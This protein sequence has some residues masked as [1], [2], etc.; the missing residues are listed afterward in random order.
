MNG[1]P[2]D[3]GDEMTLTLRT[4]LFLAA[5]GLFFVFALMG[6]DVLGPSEHNQLVL[7]L[8]LTSFAAAFLAK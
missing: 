4:A 2:L 6:T 7:G 5:V 1:V 8:G 3:P